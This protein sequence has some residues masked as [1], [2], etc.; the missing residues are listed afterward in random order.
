[1]DLTGAGRAD[2][3]DEVFTLNRERCLIQ[4]RG[5]GVVVLDT[6]RNSITALVAA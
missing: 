1:M 4:A 3:E 5:A 6:P 2:H